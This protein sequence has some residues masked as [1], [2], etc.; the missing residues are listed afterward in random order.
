VAHRIAAEITGI[1]A[2]AEFDGYGYC[3]LEAGQG[4]AGMAF[5]NFF[6][7]PSPQVELRR[8]GQV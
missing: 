4:I 2:L 6:A 1:P 7:E 8:P 3:M 5:G